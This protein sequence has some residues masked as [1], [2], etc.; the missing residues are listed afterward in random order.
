MLPELPGDEVTEPPWTST[1]SSLAMKRAMPGASRLMATPATM[2]LT[3]NVVVARLD[4]NPKSM[5]P[6]IPPRSAIH[7]PNSH[8]HQPAKMVPITIIP[9]MPM[10]T[11]PLRSATSAS[12]PGEGDRR[13]SSQP[14]SE[15]AAGGEVG[16]VGDQPGDRHHGN[17]DHHDREDPPTCRMQERPPAV[18][19]DRGGVDRGRHEVAPIGICGLSGGG[20]SS[21]VAAAA[22]ATAAASL[23]RRTTS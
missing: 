17:A 4:S 6:T 8:P 2:W 14:G 9:S 3:P 21:R 18:G 15:R 19:L 22:L 7:G 5:P 12:Q 20:R 16:V 13:R 23:R 1:N 11:V 10:L